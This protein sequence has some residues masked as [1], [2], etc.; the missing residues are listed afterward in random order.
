LKSLNTEAETADAEAVALDEQERP[1][2]KSAQLKKQDA[3]LEIVRQ[4]NMKSFQP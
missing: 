2:K 3:D 1:Q 4:K